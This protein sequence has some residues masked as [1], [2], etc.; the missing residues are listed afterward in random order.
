MFIFSLKT[1][2]KI[3]FWLNLNCLLFYTEVLLEHTD[4]SL[5]Y[6]NNFIQVN[7]LVFNQSTVCLSQSNSNLNYETNIL[8]P[9]KNS[10]NE[11]LQLL[12]KP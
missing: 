5:F 6:V 9:N 1:K 2:K 10:F 7:T 4:R 11:H 12:R 3:F 8:F